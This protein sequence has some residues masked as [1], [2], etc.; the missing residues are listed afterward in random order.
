MP[1]TQAMEVILLSQG[2]YPFSETIFQDFSRT[3]QDFRLF[4]P[5]LQKHIRYNNT[6]KFC[7]FVLGK[8]VITLFSL[9]D[10]QDFPG[11]AVFSRTFQ[12][13]KNVTTKFQDFPGFP[14]PV[15][16]LLPPSSSFSPPLCQT[17]VWK[18]NSFLQHLN[19]KISIE[20]ANLHLSFTGFYS[21]YK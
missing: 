3:F 1:A 11:P 17:K 14:G 18:A 13:W 4:F 15:Q 8:N 16:T 20:R 5:G 10:F 2:S 6:K 7:S 19:F 9:T 12:S 21:N